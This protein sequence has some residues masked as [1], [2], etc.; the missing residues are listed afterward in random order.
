MHL[1]QFF[2]T[3]YDNWKTKLVRNSVLMAFNFKPNKTA[4]MKLD[5]R[6]FK[7]RAIY[8]LICMQ[9]AENFILC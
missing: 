8:T 9:M 7:K 1:M 4:A 5:A 3:R 2:L 6:D